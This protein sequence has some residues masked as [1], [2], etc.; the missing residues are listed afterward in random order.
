MCCIDQ[1][2]PAGLNKDAPILAQVGP[3]LVAA[4]WQRTW[5]SRALSGRIRQWPD[6]LLP[7]GGPS[8]RCISELGAQTCEGRPPLL[9]QPS[10]G[11]HHQDSVVRPLPH[12]AAVRPGFSMFSSYSQVGGASTL[13]PGPR[14]LVLRDPP[15]GTSL[16]LESWLGVLRLAALAADRVLAAPLCFPCSG[17]ELLGR[18]RPLPIP[19]LSSQVPE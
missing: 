7:A 15:P 12:A 17:G 18:H 3:K 16:A 2:E 13:G 19:R 6:T 14:L 5:Q 10:V 1:S 4:S 8:W 9:P 11:E